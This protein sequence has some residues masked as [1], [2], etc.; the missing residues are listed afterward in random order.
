MNMCVRG[1]PGC[2]A[3]MRGESMSGRDADSRMQGYDKQVPL[4]R[5]VQ[6]NWMI[7]LQLVTNQSS[8]ITN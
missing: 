8:R 2:A 3:D 4:I 5:R 1:S 7:A 6:I